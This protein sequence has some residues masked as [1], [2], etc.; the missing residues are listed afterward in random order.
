MTT[1]RQTFSAGTVVAGGML[2]M[3]LAIYVFTVVAARV[4]VPAELGALVALL[5]VLL[6]G[7]VVALG[8]QAATARR[9]AVDPARADAVVAGVLR[10]AAVASVLVGSL[11]AVS[12]LALTPLLRLDSPWPVVLAG[13]TLVPLTLMGAQAGIAQGSERWA[14]LT[15]IYVAN[16]V[17]R[18]GGGVAA[19]L[20]DPSATAA[21]VGIA[22]GS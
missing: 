13:A 16:G 1:T 21:M 8:L 4:A 20:V 22:A 11:V 3:N 7:N 15:S 12:T 5:N 6:L 9:I 10:V 14:T 2:A 18:L 19:L 17:G